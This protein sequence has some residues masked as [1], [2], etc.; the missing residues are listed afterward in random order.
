MDRRDRPLRSIAAV[1]SQSL[2]TLRSVE[3]IAAVPFALQKECRLGYTGLDRL[4]HADATISGR[5]LSRW[6]IEDLVAVTNPLPICR[7]LTQ[8]PR[9]QSLSFICTQD[10]P[11]AR[12]VRAESSFSFDYNPAMATFDD[13]DLTF[14]YPDDWEVSVDG[15]AAE[16]TIS[17]E[18]PDSAFLVITVFNEQISS[19][20]VVRRAEETFT[21]IYE[22]ADVENFEGDIL[23]FPTDGTVIDFSS[24][25]L[26]GQ[27]RLQSFTT[28][29]RTFF[30]M[31]QRSDMDGDTA[32]EVFA[33]ILESLR[34]PNE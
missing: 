3:L 27:A 20:A 6:P 31:S 1:L 13:F 12:R 19:L 34:L 25:D 24:L 8:P 18:S 2:K 7:A 22:G 16:R 32:D 26:I 4:R 5:P 33:A 21:E 11:Q 15:E 28:H 14:E 10:T 29:R 9:P 30:V 23:G 17:V